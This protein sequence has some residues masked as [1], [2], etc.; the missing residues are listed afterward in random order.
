[1]LSAITLIV[2]LV[3][4]VGGGA[5]LVRG[6]S[7]IATSLGVS[8]LVV[9]LTVVGFGTSSPE[10]VVN[11][12]GA[13]SGATDLAFGNVVGSNIS[14]LALVLGAAALMSPIRI[15]SALVRR[16][17]PLLLLGTTILTVMALDGVLE[18]R[19]AVISRSDAIVL[20]LLFGI[21]IYTNVLDFFQTRHKDSLL[22]EMGAYPL[23]AT[24]AADP[25]RWPMAI[26]G[27]IMLFV[28]GH[29]TVNGATG[30][31]VQLGI[32]ETVVG[33][34]VVAIGTSLPELVT[35]IIAAVKKEA[36]LALG[37]VIG[38]NLFNSLAVLP[39][40]GLV[41]SVPVPRGGV[42]DLLL[43]WGLAAFLVPVFFLGK[44]QLG[45]AI[46]V[47]LILV[48]VGYAFLRITYIDG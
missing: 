25:W 44:A 11:I 23:I 8:P 12:I 22:L 43:S 39:A 26:G 14:N 28:G 16:E 5:L 17:L 18:G 27:M 2:G 21:F 3:L 30:L 34:F 40:S 33:L 4:L 15:Q 9:G 38:S 13:S 10:L 31:A 41:A 32:S 1:M 24:D 29:L 45:R 36:D 19:P 37:N 35:S 42:S 20:L 6:A 48:Y 47:F 46:G 7:E